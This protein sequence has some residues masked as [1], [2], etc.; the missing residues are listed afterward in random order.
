MATTF[1]APICPAILD[2]AAISS[3]EN[4]FPKSIP[5]ISK[6]VGSGTAL[7]AISATPSTNV[8]A[9]TAPVISPLAKLSCANF[10]AVSA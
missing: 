10:I 6:D 4:S 9:C 2:K 8:I 7:K 1:P 3:G 5:D